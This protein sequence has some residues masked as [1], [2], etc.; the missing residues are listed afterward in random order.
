MQVITLSEAQASLPELL[1]GMSPGDEVMIV[2]AG[3][4]LA[5]LVAAERTALA[6]RK[7]GSAKGKLRILQEDDEYLDDFEGYMP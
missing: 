7:P 4:P 1:Q 5:R 3:R 2:L 6:P